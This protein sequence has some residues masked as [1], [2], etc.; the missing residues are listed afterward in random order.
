M[1]DEFTSVSFF[2]LV[3][4][5]HLQSNF[6]PVS[7]SVVFPIL[8]VSYRSSFVY[9]PLIVVSQVAFTAVDF[10]ECQCSY[11]PLGG[12]PIHTNYLSSRLGSRRNLWVTCFAFV[13]SSM[14]YLH[15]SLHG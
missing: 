14:T 12:T 5:Y 1:H 10:C 4:L 2:I 7:K 13:V 8:I 15:T 11:Y 3:L 6:I 9:A